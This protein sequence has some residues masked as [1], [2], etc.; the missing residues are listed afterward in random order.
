MWLTVANH[1]L[2]L[3]LNCYGLASFVSGSTEKGQ[4]F[5]RTLYRV[6]QREL[7]IGNVAYFE[8]QLL[9]NLNTI[10]TRLL[11][12]RHRYQRLRHHSV[13]KAH[14]VHGRLRCPRVEHVTM[15]PVNTPLL[16][17]SSP[18]S[19][20]DSTAVVGRQEHSAR[21]GRYRHGGRP[22]DAAALL[23]RVSGY[24]G[25]CAVH[26]YHS[27]LRPCRLQALLRLRVGL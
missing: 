23:T 12:I 9:M 10:F 17:A 24:G 5:L 22:E 13:I 19:P 4:N 25:P 8:N 11:I 15:L 14:S 20:G 6:A 21:Q 1:R 26:R 27:L 2:F 7:P 16:T 3:V 18:P